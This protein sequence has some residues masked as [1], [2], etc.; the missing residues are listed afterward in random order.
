MLADQARPKADAV[1]PNGDAH[2]AVTRA[3]EVVQALEAAL[4]LA[5]KHE[6]ELLKKLT[7]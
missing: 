2:V 1:S 5:R 4:A 6:Q 7:R 3:H